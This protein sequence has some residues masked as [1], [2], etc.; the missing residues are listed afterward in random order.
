MAA[1]SFLVHLRQLAEGKLFVQ[2]RMI[3]NYCLG[4]LRNMNYDSFYKKEL[5]LRKELGFPPFRHLVSIVLRGK[6]E[7]LVLKQSKELYAALEDGNGKENDKIEILDIHPDAM[8]KL[9]DKYRFAIT[10]KGKSVEKML[11]FIKK[12]LGSFKKK[13]GVIVTVDV[14]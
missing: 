2:T 3:D 4:A 8:P 1:F 12:A 6:E 10:V 11:N 5:K 9:R 7:E 13:K 14:D